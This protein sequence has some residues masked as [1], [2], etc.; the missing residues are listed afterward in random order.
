M[1][2]D[3]PEKPEPPQQPALPVYLD[4]QATTQVDP[5]VVAAMLPFFDQEYGNAAS[6]THAFGWQAKEAVDQARQQIA[7]TIGAAPGEIV[8]TSGATESNNL[9]IRGLAER[10]NRRGNHLITVATEHKAV[11]DPIARLGRQGFEVTILGVEQAPSRRAGSIDLVE[12]AA[13]IR[14][15]TLLVSVMLANNEIGV[16]QPLA[17]IGRLCRERGVLLHCD[18]TQALGKLPIDVQALGIDLAS[19]SATKSMAP[20]AWA[21]SMCGVD[22]RPCGSNRKSPAAAT[23][24][25][26]GAA[27]STCRASSA[28][29]RRSISARPN[30]RPSKPAWPRCA[31]NCS[32]GCAAS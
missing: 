23:S 13:A 27:R 5:R 19:F 12:L 3:R 28:L 2:A 29:R 32:T 10:K 30:G 25:A 31:T 15:D 14:D 26:C 22:R 24:T 4:N 8:F 6:T 11:L 18:A 9:A 16:V 20:K 7:E 1:P 21:R 17:E